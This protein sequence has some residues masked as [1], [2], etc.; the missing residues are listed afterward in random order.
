[1]A[2]AVPSLSRAATPL[3]TQYIAPVDDP[4]WEN[5][6]TN[7]TYGANESFTFNLVSANDSDYKNY[8]IK[9]DNV[10]KVA[11]NKWVK[12][13]PPSGFAASWDG[14]YARKA[15]SCDL[16]L[17]PVNAET[18]SGG[19]IFKPGTNE[20]TT[21]SN[22]WKIN[23]NAIKQNQLEDDSEGASY[24]QCAHTDWV[25]RVTFDAN[26]GSGTMK[27]F[28]FT[29]SA[30][31]PANAFTKTGADFLRWRVGESANF[32][33]DGAIVSND[34]DLRA[35]W[36]AYTFNIVAQ[37][38]GNGTVAGGGTYDYGTQCTLSATPATGRHFV[39]WEDA[40]TYQLSD[41]NP[42][43]FAVTK[44]LNAKA[45]FE[46]NSY[47]IRFD[48]NGGSEGNVDE[49][50]CAYGTQYYLSEWNPLITKDGYTFDGWSL[51][52]DGAKSYNDGEQILNLSSEHDA[53]VV[54]Y[55]HW[56]PTVLTVV[57]DA[58]GG[59]FESGK[60]TYS[61]ERRIGDEFGE[62]SVPTNSAQVVFAGWWTST[63]ASERVQ[64]FPAD[65]VDNATT[66]II[67]RWKSVAEPKLCN[68][69]FKDGSKTLWTTNAV[70]GSE[71]GEY[72]LSPVPTNGEYSLFGWY[73]D[74]A[75]V[76]ETDVI[77]GDATLTAKWTLA[78]FNEA[79]N[80]RDVR[81]ETKGEGG[82][83][84]WTL[85]A[86]TGIAK[87]G[88]LP[89]TMGVND[90]VWSILVMTP[91]RA[92]KISLEIKSSCA[93]WMENIGYLASLA[94][95]RNKGNNIAVLSGVS[96][97]FTSTP[98][99][100]VEAGDAVT[101]EYYQLGTEARGYADPDAEE[102][103]WARNLVWEPDAIESALPDWSALAGTSLTAEAGGGAEWTVSPDAAEE[104]AVSNMPHART[105][106]LSVNVTKPRA[107]E[108]RFKWRVN[109]EG[110]YVDTNGVYQ[111]CDRLE[112]SDE[113]GGEVLRVEG[114]MDGFAEVVWT[115][116]VESAHVFTW[117][118]IKDGDTKEGEDGAWL[119]DVVWTPFGGEPEEPTETVVEY[120]YEEDGEVKH[121]S[122][123]VPNTWVDE[124]RL[125]ETTGE[126]DYL[127]ALK[128]S[129]GKIGYG[130]APLCYWADY[131]AGTVPTNPAS[132]FRVTGFSVV[133]G[134]IIITWDPDRDDREYTVW[135]K[136]NLTDAA[137]HT[138]TN[139]ASRFFR[140]EVDLPKK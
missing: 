138:P 90:D 32:V 26:G 2:L 49:M 64:V 101:L 45:R 14:K 104:V 40:N 85:D 139:S 123:A 54:L 95:Y 126:S 37:N 4:T 125:M 103:G 74:G 18:Y 42:W 16:Y 108:L 76:R 80:C 71:F 20:K 88:D 58:N 61:V 93:P 41:S 33:Q 17:Y 91:E 124:Y 78:A 43:K 66:N 15:D 129:S 29:N 28:V 92:G 136:T 87:S 114:L 113:R 63:N 79:W 46:L 73:K 55:A 59:A 44:D 51:T 50:T 110:G 84:G 25:Y 115:N 8:C 111:V 5:A 24:V 130:G 89:E 83:A 86:K 120:D 128:R 27:D 72:F 105:A 118:Y 9:V 48:S 68:L 39:R 132:V 116:E 127:A 36:N 31:L 135:G 96:D 21:I 119:R 56:K 131:V 53:V 97:A 7:T 140:V 3:I 10:Y 109:G 65:I 106:W 60:K 99:T 94:L 112:F 23:E 70:E 122:V 38:L 47:K 35:V 107:G 82:V 12:L 134:A 75:R 77:E 22:M 57:F 34:L 69:V 67:A 19:I 30:A 62:V 1:M 81:F 6:V 98:V 11:W 52:P 133:D 100:H 137:W 13:A 121:G 117:R 102:C